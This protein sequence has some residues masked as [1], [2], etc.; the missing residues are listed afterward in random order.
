MKKT[1]YINAFASV[2]AL[3][4]SKEEVWSA[5]QLGDA[6]FQKQKLNA[7]THYVSPVSNGVEKELE[8]LKQENKAYQHLDKSVLLGI[9]ASRKL[10]EDMG[11]HASISLQNTGVNLGSS[12]GA[13]HLFET[14]HEEFLTNGSVPGR[15]SPSTTLGNLSSWIAQDLGTSG[16][17]ISH[18]ITCSTALHGVLNALA[19]LQSGMASSFIVGGAEAPLTAFTIAQLEALKLYS[20]ENEHK[21]CRSLDFQK[22]TNSLVLGEAAAVFLLSSEAKNAKAKIL[23]IGYANEQIKHSIS[24]STDARCFQ[25]S[26]KMA[27]KHAGL[28][29]VDAIVMHAPGTVK[30]DIAELKAI[31]KTFSKTPFLTT[32]KW[33][34]G[35]TYGASG[36]MS[37]EM[38]IFMLRH[39]TY[40]SNPFY[41]NP[42]RLSKP[43]H[44]MINAVGFGGNAVS[45]IIGKS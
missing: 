40:I 6:F 36:G 5:Y 12:R 7:N 42:P 9:L 38:A 31:E 22:K 45:I 34:I 30:G 37:L 10:M 2:S 35:H 3:G 13:T 41:T 16:A 8:T 33:K 1:I 23:G 43:Q 26:M 4:A 32:N 18:S 44:I 28:N 17:V 14:F 24:I 21:A 25:Q 27:L 15:T 39:Q 29:S 19:W 11:Q 20:S